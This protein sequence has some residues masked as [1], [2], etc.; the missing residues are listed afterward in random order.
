MAITPGKVK[1]D[2]INQL[3]K[4]GVANVNTTILF[5]QYNRLRRK[6]VFEHW[7]SWN[8]GHEE[9]AFAL[10][11]STGLYVANMPATADK[12]RAPKMWSVIHSS[13]KSWHAASYRELF[14][15]YH[16]GDVPKYWVDKKN[17]KIWSNCGATEGTADFQVELSD[18]PIDTTQDS[19]EEPFPDGEAVTNGLSGM[20][21]LATQ[22][23]DEQYDRFMD[24]YDAQVAEDIAIDIQDEPA[25]FDI[26]L[27]VSVRR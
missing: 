3:N 13:P 1:E 10:D 2:A 20:Y 14:T 7:W 22:R 24:A 4:A 11:V 25:I 23:K 19:N 6:Y 18:L 12:K 27:P 16:S 15:T 9:L 5:Q 8:E 21:W 17:G 26:A